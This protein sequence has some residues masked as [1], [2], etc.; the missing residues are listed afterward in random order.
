[1][2]KEEIL[3]HKYIWGFAY[4][5]P[6]KHVVT[7][8]GIELEERDKLLRIETSDLH[9]NE[10]SFIYIWGWPGPDYNRY[11]YEDFGKT[12]CF[13]PREIPSAAVAEV[14]IKYLEEDDEHS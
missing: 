8:E 13:H 5:N 3:K 11:K 4:G 6:V 7:C 10:N 14:H 12:W 1:M 9:F 2:T